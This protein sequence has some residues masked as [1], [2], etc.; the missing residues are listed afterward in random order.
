MVVDGRTIDHTEALDA[1]V[2][3][4]VSIVVFAQVKLHAVIVVVVRFA[5]QGF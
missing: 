4:N 5:V 1:L 2:H 3:G